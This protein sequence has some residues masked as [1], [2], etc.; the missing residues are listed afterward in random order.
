MSD[1]PPSPTRQSRIHRGYR[2][3]ATQLGAGWIGTVYEPPDNA[4][5]GNIE[6]ASAEEFMIRGVDVVNRL[7]ASES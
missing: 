7:L 5:V 2:I 4:I 3:V 6:G 1:L